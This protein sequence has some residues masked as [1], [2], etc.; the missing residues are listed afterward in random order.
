MVRYFDE[1]FHSLIVSK[2]VRAG[3]TFPVARVHRHLR[4]RKYASRI[5]V[6]SAVYAAVVLEYLTA[7]ILELAG[8]EAAD[9]KKML[10]T[11]R[12]I[13]LAVRKDEELS[14]LF[15]DVTISN[16]GV[17]PRVHSCLINVKKK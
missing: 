10:I 7:E 4:K 6:G 16:A 17:V 11:P 1:P 3:I 9:N 15:K 2:T 14:N 5:R 13:M 12:H 8:N